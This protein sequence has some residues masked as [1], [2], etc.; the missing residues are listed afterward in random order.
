MGYSDFP[1]VDHIGIVAGNL[2]WSLAKTRIL[3]PN[4]KSD[5]DVIGERDLWVEHASTIVLL[6][7]QDSCEMRRL[8]FFATSLYLVTFLSL[9]GLDLSWHC[10]FV[11]ILEILIRSDRGE[12]YFQCSVKQAI[13]RH[14]T[15]MPI[16]NGCK[17]S[18]Y[19][20]WV[21]TAEYSGQRGREPNYSLASLVFEDIER[22]RVHTQTGSWL[23]FGNPDDHLKAVA[24]NWILAHVEDLL[25][26]SQWETVGQLVS[27]KLFKTSY[28]YQFYRNQR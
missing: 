4:C 21:T 10:A 7:Y 20:S 8:T 27:F 2:L 5:W 25:G 22:P 15:N 1:I 19:E 6:I 28:M 17:Y 13:W 18:W 9:L 24:T 14:I 12:V 16:I 11:H 3:N 26:Y 23:R